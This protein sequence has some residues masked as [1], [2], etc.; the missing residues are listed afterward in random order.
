MKTQIDMWY[1]DVF[2]PKKHTIDCFFSDCDCVY[3][4]N[5]YNENGKVIG[6]YQSPD[7]CWIQRFFNINFGR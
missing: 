1:G 4:G 7:S 5:I 6:D 2:D 3:R